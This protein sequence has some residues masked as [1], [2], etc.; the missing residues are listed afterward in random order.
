MV[1][2]ARRADRE[3]DDDERQRTLGFTRSSGTIF[4]P[5]DIFLHNGTPR[6]FT[7]ISAK[8]GGGV[9]V[10]ALERRQAFLATMLSGDA[11]ADRLAALLP[12]GSQFDNRAAQSLS[13]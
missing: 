6:R 12:A 5:R 2:P 4:K 11:D 9:V 7:D 1:V 3:N 13:M 10:A 8:L